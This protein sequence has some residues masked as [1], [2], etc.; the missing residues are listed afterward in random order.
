MLPSVDTRKEYLFL[1]FKPAF[2]YIERYFSSSLT[3]FD[4]I[5]FARDSDKGTIR[6][7]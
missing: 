2:L 1:L 4:E 5:L 3:V 6:I 7:K